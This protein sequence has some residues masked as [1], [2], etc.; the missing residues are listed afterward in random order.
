M[1]LQQYHHESLS[2]YWP[3]MIVRAG[4]RV[5]HLTPV[6]FRL[7]SALVR[8]QGKVARYNELISEVWGEDRIGERA[9]LKLYIWYLRRKIERD[10]SNPEL[11]HTCRGIGYV[12]APEPTG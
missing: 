8:R 5:V 6:E 4:G 12:F 10:P 11:I 7:L 2:I 9:N 1:Q 3:E